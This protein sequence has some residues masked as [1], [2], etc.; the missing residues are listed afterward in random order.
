MLVLSFVSR[1][2][3]KG[4][5][6]NS[7]RGGAGRCKLRHV[8][9]HVMRHLTSCYGHDISWLSQLARN[10]LVRKIGGTTNT[11]K[12]GVATPIFLVQ[13]ICYTVRT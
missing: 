1:A 8:I 10:Y 5:L 12:Y 9:S 7:T 4:A 11:Q 6:A 13:H 2:N 3:L